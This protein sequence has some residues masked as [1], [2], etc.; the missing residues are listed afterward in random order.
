M[1]DKI[2]DWQTEFD[3]MVLETDDYA[4]TP[5]E[6][7]DVTLL[8]GSPAEIK[9][10]ITSLLQSERERLIAGIEGMKV[11]RELCLTGDPCEFENRALNF[12]IRFIKGGE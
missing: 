11:P 7:N 8:K 2:K 5:D 10:F 9:A 1:S 3:Q 4:G 6:G 12:V